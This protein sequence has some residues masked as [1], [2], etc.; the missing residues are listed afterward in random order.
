MEYKYLKKYAK[1]IDKPIRKVVGREQEV[2]SILAA[3]LR[4]ELSNVLLLGNAGAGKT[5]II[6]E[7]ARIDKREYFEVDLSRMVESTASSNGEKELGMRLS[8]LVK[9]VVQYER[10]NKKEIVLFI[11]E[12]HQLVQLSPSAAES[13]K[14]ILAKSG[15]LGIRIIA[16]TTYDEFTEHIQKNQPL[17]ERL[18]RIN[19]QAPPREVV[20]DILKSI[21]D[22]NKCSVDSS[23][24]ENIYDYTERYLPSQSQPR[25]S[26]LIL[27]GMIGWH[28]AFNES[29]NKKLLDK[30]IFEATGINSNWDLE[31]ENMKEYLMYRVLDQDFAIESI[32]KRLHISVADLNETSKPQ[33]SFL[34]TGSTGVGKT[35]LAKALASCLFGSENSLL[36]FDMSEFSNEN[37]VEVFREQLSDR[38]WQKPYSVILLDEIEKAHPTVVKLL[39]QVLDDARISNRFGKEVTFQNAYVLITTNV[40]SEVYSSALDYA[41]NDDKGLESYN[42][43]I[44]KALLNSPVFSPELINRVDMIIPFKPLS[45][46]SLMKIAKK[47]IGELRNLIAR[48]HNIVVH[49]DELIINYLILENL[50]TST[51]GGGG[52]SIKRRIDDEITSKLAEFLNLYPSIRNVSVMVEGK[53][54]ST[55][56]KERTGNARIIVGSFNGISRG[57]FK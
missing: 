56:K 47:R 41:D 13:I 2:R 24:F 49:F 53:M 25:K 39:L 57:G 1:G 46:E 40:A 3:M 10:E 34:F 50:D 6:S 12:F 35:E 15:Q 42:R 51:N 37:S 9:D 23:I 29:F 38:V 48:K 8:L 22:K 7:L 26:I 54:R 27:D 32:I 43:V 30:V 52:R 18:Q 19:I 44:Q 31:M 20:L 21:A 45:R 4:P 11:D 17:L 33:G 14:P 28:K 36:R 55:D 16:A 5:A